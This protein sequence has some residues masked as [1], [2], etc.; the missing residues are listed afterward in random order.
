MTSSEDVLTEQPP[1]RFV[2]ATM[3]GELSEAE[4][5]SRY[6][7]AASLVEGRRVLDV[8]CGTAYGSA[9]LREAGA[10][11]VVG[12]DI[13][14]AVIE[15]ARP[16]MPE[17]VELVV[18]DVQHLELEARVFDVVVCFETIEHVK[19]REAALDGLARVLAPG[20]VLVISSPNRDA[21]VPGNPH[22]VFEYAPDEL[23]AAL[24]ARFPQVRLY[25]Q[26]GLLG[27]AVLGPDDGASAGAPVPG[28]EVTVAQPGEAG[29]ETYVLALAGREPLPDPSPVMVTTGLVEVRR[30]VEL[31]QEQQ[32]VLRRQ[33]EQIQN[34]QLQHEEIAALR[35]RLREAEQELAVIPDLEED[36]RITREEHDRLY[37]FERE[38]SEM[39][40]R[41]EQ[42]EQL[43]ERADRV[44]RGL[45]SSLS[46]RITKPLRALK[47][48]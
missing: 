48:R 41:I 26:Q 15:S 3:A 17:G 11:S 20:G 25:R 44:N 7:W 29:D 43:A 42:L 37:R 21:Y 16:D 12:V 40:A 39:A 46:W 27:S 32:D 33:H 28:F 1:E 30:W 8:A 47:R 2:P 9:L 23:R 31:Y 24:S 13:A 18:G 35:A 38:R 36:A 10:A 14:E 22:H 45:Q 19:D 6:R 34:T 4:H 5:L